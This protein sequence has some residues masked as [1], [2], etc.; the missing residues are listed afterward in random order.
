MKR[1]ILHVAK[2]YASSNSTAASAI[3]QLRQIKGRLH[4]S[5]LILNDPMLGLWHNLLSS[6]ET[7][8]KGQF[9]EW[10][11]SHSTSTSTY[12]LQ[13]A[14]EDLNCCEY[15][16]VRYVLCGSRHTPIMHSSPRLV[17]ALHS[18]LA[19]SYRT[20]TSTY[21]QS[22]NICLRG[23]TPLQKGF[24][25]PPG[26]MSDDRDDAR[27]QHIHRWIRLRVQVHSLHAIVRS[28]TG[29]PIR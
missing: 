20:S 3:E 26:Y 21:G 25:S 14:Y 22:R 5:P 18:G 6:D 24:S 11:I 4:I 13:P 9:L 1:V 28:A 2:H 29:I 23:H 15:W 27:R 16:K 8:G 10:Y 12:E 19:S 7:S 17:N